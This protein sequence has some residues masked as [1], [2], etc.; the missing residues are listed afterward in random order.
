MY[1][2]KHSIFL[3]IILGLIVHKYYCKEQTYDHIPNKP[4]RFHVAEFNFDHV[5]DVYAITLWIL[6]GSLAKVGFHLS[7]RL[8][9]KFPESCLLIILG[10]IVGALLY[11]THLAE[12][13]AY[14]LNSETFFLF[15]LPPIILEAGYFMPNRPFFDNLGTI[16]LL[17]IVNTLFNTICI[18]LTLWGFQFTPIYG[19]T[20]FDM[21]PCLVFAA[22]ISAVDPV[23]VLA[24]FTEIH[25]NDM[26]YIV[27]F[28]ESLLNDAVSVVL[29]R[30]F[31]SFAK[32]GQ[33]NIIVM[34]VVLGFIA[35]FTTK[36]TEHTPV[37]EPLII[38]VYAYLAYLTSEMVSVSGILAI[39]FCGMVMKQ[40]VSFNISKKSDAT[41]E[42]VLKMLSSIMETII[43]MFMGLSTVSDNHSWN[44]GFVLMTLLLCLVYRVIGVA[45][46]AN[47]ANC[48]R[49]LELT[50]IDMLIMSYGGL[51]G[52]IAFA[53]AL[54]LDE[55]K[56]ERKKEFVTA[57]IAVVF[58]TV[59][60]QGI[61]IGPLVKLLNVRRKQIE[62]P[63]MSAK[64]T[65]RMMDHVMTCLEEISGS[66]GSHSL[67]D[68]IRNFDRNYF[69]RWLL[70]ETPQEKMDI[71]LLQTFKKISTQSAMRVH[72]TSRGLVPAATAA[73][74]SSGSSNNLKLDRRFE[75]VSELIAANLPE[76][77][78]PDLMFFENRGGDH[79]HDDAH[80]HHFLDSN[81]YSARPR[82][83]IHL[84]NQDETVSSDDG[85]QNRFEKSY[86]HRDHR[87]LPSRPERELLHGPKTISK[88]VHNG[89][90]L[91]PIHAHTTALTPRQANSRSR[92]RSIT[93]EESSPSPSHYRTK[94]LSKE[95][96]KRTPPISVHVENEGTG[97]TAAER[98]R[99]WRHLSATED[100][101]TNNSILA[102]GNDPHLHNI[103]ITGA[104]ISGTYHKSPES[105]GEY[106][107]T[108]KPEESFLRP[109][110]RDLF[111]KRSLNGSETQDDNDDNTDA[112]ESITRL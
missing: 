74:Y 9:E 52:A 105:M 92:S 79:H 110:V 1:Q 44:T 43:F 98:S 38:L 80:M 100:A 41:T 45:I 88:S 59:F 65:N 112:D 10:L 73:A 56:I 19:G 111:N 91:S 17:A 14:V 39:T 24:T 81:L 61:T 103:S 22:L 78:V 106:A 42:Y 54:V 85:A 33:A 93:Q 57:T 40:Y 58:F 55:T 53:L 76:H 64:L 75:N 71:K 104:D 68:R 12:Q 108:T 60:L 50:R 32:I 16:L 95:P 63:T 72:D 97:S 21:L 3:V 15:L 28:G 86:H 102:K 83:A 82:A 101:K 26:L 13:K 37:L 89:H 11:V 90:R 18:G 77:T 8:T 25:V 67:R 49:L 36:F 48:W 2:G 47:I 94:S 31:E 35:C 46:F 51:R 87:Y 109:D 30:M 84:R 5:S 69:K 20:Q 27:V 29:Y 66:G 70:R 96:H 6:L 62:E 4:I 7:H 107:T 34:D 99:P 23:A